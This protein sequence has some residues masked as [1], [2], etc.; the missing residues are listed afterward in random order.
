MKWLFYIAIIFCFGSSSGQSYYTNSP[1][2]INPIV[3]SFIIE[4]K[5]RGIEVEKRMATLDSIIVT[6]TGDLGGAD[7]FRGTIRLR[8]RDMGDEFQL[9]QRI[10]HEL[11]HHFGLDHCYECKYNIMSGNRNHRAAF[12]YKD[13]YLRMLYFDLFFDYLKE[14]DKEHRHY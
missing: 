1:A 10:F 14:P 2:V 11:G 5:L 12:L 13:E 4:A 9:T 6:D 3:E 8:E 7:Y